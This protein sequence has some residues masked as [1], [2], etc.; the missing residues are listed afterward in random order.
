MWGAHESRGE[1]PTRTSSVGAL[2]LA[3]AACET[4]KATEDGGGF[5]WPVAGEVTSTFGPKGGRLANDGINIAAPAGTPVKATASGVVT[6]AGNEL[7]GYGNLIL[8]KHE[9]GWISAYA[10]NEQLLVRQ[11]E[12]V[13]GGQVIARVGR[14]G[15]CARPQLHFEL[16]RG[17]TPTDP[18]LYLPVPA[19][20]P[21]PDEEAEQVDAAAC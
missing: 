20:G 13:S 5:I 6:Y 15:G 8:I 9:N 19:A 7:R 16:R 17:K 14:R 3:L 11:G 2:L 1:R 10:H 4:P 18:L 12:T 21:T